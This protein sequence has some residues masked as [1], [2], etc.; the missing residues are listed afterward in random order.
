MSLHR[1]SRKFA[2]ASQANWSK[3]KTDLKTQLAAWYHLMSE[4]MYSSSGH[5]YCCPC[6]Y[7]RSLL[8]P[9]CL[10]ACEPAC[11]GPLLTCLLALPACYNLLHPV[12]LRLHPYCFSYTCP[13]SFLSSCPQITPTSR[14]LFLL[15]L[16][17]V[18]LLSP[19]R[20]TPTPT[21]PPLHL[22]LQRLHRYYRHYR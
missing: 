14:P 22:P 12:L 17:L 9:A 15:V 11:L 2:V 5:L 8:E 20:R 16:L 7:P 1:C 4:A 10:C 3:G 19:P 18:L 6:S 13:Y 21:P